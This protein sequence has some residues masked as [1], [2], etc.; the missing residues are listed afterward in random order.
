MWPWGHAA[1]GYLLYTA[2]VYYRN[3]RQPQAVSVLTL[4]VGTQFPDLIDKTLAWE[5][6][7]L[8]NGRSLAHSLLLAGLFLTVLWVIVRRTDHRAAGAAFGV[9]YLGHVFGD[10]LYPALAGDFYELGFLAWP[11][12]PAIEYNGASSI[13]ARFLAFNFGVTELFEFAL[14]GIAIIVWYRDG[15]PG[16]SVLNPIRWMGSSA[17]ADESSDR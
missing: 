6:G 15:V 2:L 1:V 8:P 11:V 9:G 13:L 3:G 14:V 5:F 17:D 10:A 12:V 7:F 4:A 16:L